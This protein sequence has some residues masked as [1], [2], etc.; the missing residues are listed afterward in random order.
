M[1]E[2]KNKGNVILYQTSDGQSK[3]R[4]NAV[5]RYGVAHCRPNGRTVSTK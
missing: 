5:G 4:G 3:N 2:E 1:S